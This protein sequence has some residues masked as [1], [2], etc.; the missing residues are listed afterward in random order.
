MKRISFVLLLSAAWYVPF[1]LAICADILAGVRVLLIAVAV[2]VFSVW[3]VVVMRVSP[4]SKPAAAQGSC[5]PPSND[6]PAPPP[7]RH[8]L[9]YNGWPTLPPSHS[10]PPAAQHPAVLPEPDPPQMP[11]K[12]TRAGALIL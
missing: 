3:R 6:R 7:V 4:G 1:L 5:S 2:V 9:S 8:V 10:E 12:R 11:D